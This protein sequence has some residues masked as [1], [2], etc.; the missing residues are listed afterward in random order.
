MSYTNKQIRDFLTEFFADDP[1]EFEFF[2]DDYYLN[3]K[4]QFSDGMTPKR[5]AHLLTLHVAESGGFDQLLDNLKAY[6]PDVFAA[7]AHLLP[8]AEPAEPQPASDRAAAVGDGA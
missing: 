1:E 6:Q 3:V 5:R 2:C 8:T 4:E 7:K